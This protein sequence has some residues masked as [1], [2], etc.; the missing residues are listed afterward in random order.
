MFSAGVFLDLM[1]QLH[2]LLIRA[3]VI[4]RFFCKDSRTP[5]IGFHS[6]QEAMAHGLRSI[7]IRLYYPLNS[8]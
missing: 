2:Q 6:F 7:G 1:G 4:Y 3:T 5:V 8:H